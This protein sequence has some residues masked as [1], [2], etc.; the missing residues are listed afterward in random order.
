[1]RQRAPWQPESTG[2]TAVGSIWPTAKQRLLLRAA[3]LRGEEEVGAWQ[4]W[5][6]GI[7]WDADFDRGSFRLLPL[8]YVNMQRCGVTH[9][10]LQKLKG[11]YR[12]A[13]YETNSLFYRLRDDIVALRQAGHDVMLVKGAPLALTYY[14]SLGARP[15]SDIDVIVPTSQA[16]AAL[17]VMEQRGW[18]RFSMARDE[19][20]VYRH[21]MLFRDSAGY[22]CDLHWHVL[23]ECCQDDADSDF[24][25]AATELDFQGIP[26]KTLHAVDQFLLVIMHGI[27]WNPEPA[28]RWIADAATIVREAG[29]TFDWPRLLRQAQQRQLV[30]RLTMGLQYL[31]QEMDVPI[32]PCVL[33]Q[34]AAVR[35][36]AVERLE[37]ACIL[38]PEAD[39][40]RT[41]L[42]PIKLIYADY[43]RFAGDLGLWRTLTDFPHYLRYRW[44]ME[45]RRDV[46]KLILR[47][48]L[49][50]SVEVL[51]GHRQALELPESVR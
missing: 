36:S 6:Q 16:Q 9:P 46:L 38:Q 19:D 43:G 21:S 44:R 23:Q 20:L 8:L 13:W 27:R 11:L 2:N 45:G 51:L 39:V 30:L 37:S 26:V 32:P 31:A 4:Q 1:M 12:R 47:K 7:D 42:G 5:L 50:R 35:I 18:Q 22:E 33:Q 48:G 25:Q 14:R 15:M 49:Q 28:I 3:L 17:A 29:A 41:F 10:T 34:L 24:W 40:Y